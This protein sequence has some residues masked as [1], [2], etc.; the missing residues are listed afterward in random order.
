MNREVNGKTPEEI[1]A[2]AKEAMVGV[3]GTWII[4]E[5]PTSV[6][7]EGQQ[8]MGGVDQAIGAGMALFG[9]M[10]GLQA[11]LQQATAMAIAGRRVVT[12]LCQPTA[13]GVKVTYPE[14]D[15]DAS[16]VHAGLDFWFRDTVLGEDLPLVLFKTRDSGH[17]LTVR[18]RSVE[19]FTQG[20]TKGSTGGETRPIQDIISVSSDGRKV[21]LQLNDGSEFTVKAPSAEEAGQAVDVI[22]S[23][24]ATLG[25]ATV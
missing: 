4:H 16:T 11:G 8:G 25:G 17:T 20:W 2:A 23:R 14:L 15:P 6:T 7:F 1:L 5:G 10:Q 3:A 21:T 19:L 13:G 9:G 18:N 12:L 24:Q 22:E